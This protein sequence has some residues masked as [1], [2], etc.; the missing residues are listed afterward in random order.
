MA[1][2]FRY[3][4]NS[5]QTNVVTALGLTA[6]VTFLV[7]L[8]A[9][10][11]GSAHVSL[12]T[13]VAAVTFFAFCSATMIWRY[14][15]GQVVMAVRPD[16]LFDARHSAQAML[17]EDMRTLELR[18]AENEFRLVISK[19]GQGGSAKDIELDLAALDADVGTIIE[20]ISAYRPV[21]VRGA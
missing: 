15:R 11:A 12:I 2:R 5:F 3:S 16:G 13:T 21:D 9:R 19:W 8:F 4:R 10:L 18:R 14:A 17:W 1:A 7:W 6:I 20:A